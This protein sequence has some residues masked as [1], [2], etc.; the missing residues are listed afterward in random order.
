MAANVPL[1]T[2]FLSDAAEKDAD[3]AHDRLRDV[4][5]SADK[6]AAEELQETEPGEIVN[7]PLKLVPRQYQQRLFERAKDGNILAVLDTG[8]GKTL[9]ALMLL[10]HVHEL[11]PR[12]GLR[13]RVSF[14][15]VPA[16]PLVLQQ[17]KYIEYNSDL[18]VKFYYGSMGVDQ[19]DKATWTIALEA[20]DCLVMTPAIFE[21]MLRKAF[22]QMSNVNLIVFDECHHARKAAI[23]NQIMT[24]YY[25]RCPEEAR[26]KIFGM[27][28]SPATSQDARNAIK[29][30]EANLHSVAFTA[31]DVSDIKQYRT[32]P[33]EDILSYPFVSRK[34]I[35]L[36]HLESLDLE[37]TETLKKLVADAL[38]ISEELGPWCCDRFL[39]QIFDG[40]RKPVVAPTPGADQPAFDDEMD[41]TLL[42][43][44][45]VFIES[46]KYK[47]RPLPP[48]ELLSPKL[49]LLI[50]TLAAYRDSA[51]FCGIVF[52]ERRVTAHM[53]HCVLPLIPELSFLKTACLMGHGVGSQTGWMK[54]KEFSMQVHEQR[55]VVEGFKVGYYNL[56]IATRVVAVP[57]PMV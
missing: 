9:I 45:D 18:R 35:L 14:F 25:A 16:V 23:Y 40:Y 1:A 24:L 42:L 13:R 11:E 38:S 53:L 12:T 7:V 21:N 39:K 56:L 26:P 36:E 34:S 31:D 55:K 5:E 48:V 28:A 4:E 2:S 37:A 6:D 47:L 52:T 49:L 43:E 33:V 8:L 27:T 50:N 15:L 57:L 54:R 3:D 10:K 19:W 41:R 17:A 44:F 22:V 46:S 20:A 29:E 30:L 32:K 51:E